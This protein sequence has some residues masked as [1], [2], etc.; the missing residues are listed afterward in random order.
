MGAQ[1]WPTVCPPAQVRTWPRGGR[2]E[3]WSPADLATSRPS[4]LKPPLVHGTT[5]IPKPLGRFPRPKALSLPLF[6]ESLAVPG[7]RGSGPR[8]KI[9]RIPPS[10]RSQLGIVLYVYRLPLRPLAWPPPGSPEVVSHTS[11][12]VLPPSLEAHCAS[13]SPRSPPH[14]HPLRSPSPRHT[15]VHA[16]HAPL[17]ALGMRRAPPAH[18]SGSAATTPLRR[19]GPRAWYGPSRFP[20]SRLLAPLSRWSPQP[21]AR[22]VASAQPARPAPVMVRPRRAPHRS[23]A[24]GPLGGRGRPPRPLTVRAARS[25]SWPASPRGPQP[26]RIRARS[27][28]PMVSPPRPFSRAFHGPAPRAPV[29]VRDPLSSGVSRVAPKGGPAWGRV[30]PWNPS[31]VRAGLSPLLRVRAGAAGVGYGGGAGSNYC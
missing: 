21:P 6:L 16:G 10:P 5:R 25:R 14:T 2:W 12:R 3:L 18:R 13:Q 29:F 27:A 31:V 19:R 23:G 4:N 26:P 7:L 24:G 1:L 15:L 28:P 8:A 22:P 17:G 9:S 30:P 11:S 20:E